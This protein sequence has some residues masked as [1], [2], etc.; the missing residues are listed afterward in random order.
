MF[1]VLSIV[2]HRRVYP[3]RYAWKRL[4]L[5]LA[6]PVLLAGAVGCGGGGGSGAATTASTG[7]QRVDGTGF[8]FGAPAGWKAE[9][10][11]TSAKASQSPTRIVSVAV[12]PLV[13]PYRTALFPKVVPELDRVAAE[14][15]AKLG[16]RVTSK[17][18]VSVAGRRARQYEIVHG[19]LVDRITFVLR[20][21]ENFQL[22][23]RWRTTD[24]EPAACAQLAATFALR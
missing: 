7:G 23:C 6:V 22:T 11:P 4:A 2:A 19:D 16:G 1:R 9:V 10:Q 3:Q 14:L 12:L 21:K 5:V 17:A 13:R 20:G 24:G 18:T 8:S 15:A